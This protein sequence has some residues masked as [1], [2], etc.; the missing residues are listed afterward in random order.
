MKC[1]P[2]LRYGSVIVFIALHILQINVGS[3]MFRLRLSNQGL[4]LVGTVNIQKQ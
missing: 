4:R 3:V 2:K 1:L